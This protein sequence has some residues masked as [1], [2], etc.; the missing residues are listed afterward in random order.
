MFHMT[1]HT[2]VILLAQLTAVIFGGMLVFAVFGWA[3]GIFGTIFAF[4]WMIVSIP[5]KILFAIISLPFSLFRSNS[6]THKQ[7]KGAEYGE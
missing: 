7:R 4:L 3:I 5:L 6:N 2:I 1:Q